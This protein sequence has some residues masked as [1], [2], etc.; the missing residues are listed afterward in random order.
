MFVNGAPSSVY[1]PTEPS[2]GCDPTQ[3]S[4]DDTVFGP[5]PTAPPGP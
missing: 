2:D 5:I 3:S 4:V 1:I